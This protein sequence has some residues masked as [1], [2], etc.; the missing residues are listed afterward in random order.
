VVIAGGRTGAAVATFLLASQSA[1]A[2]AT[3]VAPAGIAAPKLSA[4]Q[5]ITVTSAASRAIVIVGE[6]TT[7]S[8]KSGI[9]VD[10]MV[11]GIE[12]G[13]TVVPYIRFPGQT[14]FTPGSARPEITDG[15]FIWQ[16]KMGKRVTVYV[17]HEDVRSN[18][19]TIQAS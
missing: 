15:E 9:L 1:A 16:R 3:Y 4:V 12:D 18:R 10:G 8:G 5:T 7:V 17:E 2:G 19:V 14:T 13:K 6:R 11:T